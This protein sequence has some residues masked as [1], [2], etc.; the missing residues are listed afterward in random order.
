MGKYIENY[1]FNYDNIDK[2]LDNYNDINVLALLLDKNEKGKRCFKAIIED[3]ENYSKINLTDGWLNMLY[4]FDTPYALVNYPLHKIKDDFIFLG[5][6][7]DLNYVF[8]KKT[9]RGFSYRVVYLKD[10]KS[11]SLEEL[12]S[13]SKID[14]YA[15]FD[16]RVS[17]Y[18]MTCSVKDFKN[19]YY[20][21]IINYVEK[22]GL[23]FKNNYG[24][25]QSVELLLR[26]EENKKIIKN[27]S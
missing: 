11:K 25:I 8:N 16:N 7:F 5:G 19:K 18:L 3:N 12:D 6:S 9:L 4:Y 23:Y 27:R 24:E 2:L 17:L 10:G 14:I 1:T 15:D 20:P 21:Y 22:N 13:K 26:D